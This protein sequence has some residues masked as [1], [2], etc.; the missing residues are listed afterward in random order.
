MTDVSVLAAAREGQAPRILPEYDA[1]GEQ[2]L[3]EAVHQ[4]LGA[5]SV[6]W[7]PMDCTGVFKSSRAAQIGA[8]L[9]GIARQYASKENNA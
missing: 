9:I 8:E 7:N 6:C 5:A 4:A 2:E 1:V 3:S